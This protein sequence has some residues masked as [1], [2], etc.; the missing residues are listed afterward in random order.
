MCIADIVLLLFFQ[1]HKC[2]HGRMR[3]EVG[4]NIMAADLWLHNLTDK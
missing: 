1:R 2:L 4:V 3:L